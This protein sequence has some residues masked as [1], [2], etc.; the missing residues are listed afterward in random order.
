MNLFRKLDQLY[1]GFLFRN[2]ICIIYTMGKVGS[3]SVYHTLKEIMPYNDIFHV[4]FL[5]DYWLNEVLPHTN[6]TNQIQFSKDLVKYI[7]QKQHKRLKIISL[8]RE[9]ISRD[10]SNIFQNPVDYVAGKNIDNVTVEELI[11]KSEEK[12]HEYTLNWFDSESK[13]F[14]NFDI[15]SLP[16]DINK[17]YKI[18][19]TKK[20]DLLLIKLENLNECY[21]DAFNA[22]FNLKISSLKVVNEG[23]TKATDKLAEKVKSKYKVKEETLSSIYRSKYVK[24]F[25]SDS[26]IEKFSSKWLELNK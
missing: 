1:K 3:S 11:E 6:H 25:Y 15:Y 14:L 13:N 10:I 7:N 5:S 2:N 16:F 18:Y 20:F 19:K 24:H 8:V 21:Q 23:N 12:G 9:P 4:H 26:E 22:F 17:G